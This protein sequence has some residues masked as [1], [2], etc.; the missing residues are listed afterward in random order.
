MTPQHYRFI[1]FV[2]HV[3]II[4]FLNSK[5]LVGT[6]IHLNESALHACLSLTHVV[7]IQ[8]I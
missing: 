4:R 2:L 3:I 5:I 6:Y 1:L 7:R 8:V